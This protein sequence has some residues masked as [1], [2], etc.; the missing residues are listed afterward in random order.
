[1]FSKCLRPKGCF[2]FFT[3][4]ILVISTVAGA[5]LVLRKIGLVDEAV[6]ALA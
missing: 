5:W 4:A 6:F 3:I 2:L 1:L